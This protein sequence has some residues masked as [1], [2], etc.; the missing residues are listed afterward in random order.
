MNRC[1]ICGKLL[2]NP[3]AKTCGPKCKSQRWRNIQSAKRQPLSH[4]ELQS[5]AW[6]NQYLPKAGESLTQLLAVHG[7]GALLLAFTAMIEYAG[8]LEAQTQ[9]GTDVQRAG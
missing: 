6:F 3:R 5:L 9:Q 4:E 1:E 7:K 8:F 2:P